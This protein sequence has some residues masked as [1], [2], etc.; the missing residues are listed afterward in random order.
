MLRQGQDRF[1]G[2]WRSCNQSLDFIQIEYFYLTGTPE[3]ERR[4]TGVIS[5]TRLGDNCCLVVPETGFASIMGRPPWL[6][7]G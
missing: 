2:H 6:T 4:F 5:I 7:G 1:L 3:R